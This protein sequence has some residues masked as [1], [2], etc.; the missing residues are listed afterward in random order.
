MNCEDLFCCVFDISLCIT[1]VCSG[2]SLNE[3]LG[4]FGIRL[5]SI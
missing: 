1:F 2:S 5:A 3:G 4:G